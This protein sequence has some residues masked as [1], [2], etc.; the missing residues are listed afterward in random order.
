MIAGLGHA[1]ELE[2]LFIS[3]AIAVV[4]RLAA[5]IGMKS[6]IRLTILT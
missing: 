6:E 3:G 2:G 5:A 4:G 1:R